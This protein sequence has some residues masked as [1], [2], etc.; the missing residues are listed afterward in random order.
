MRPNDVPVLQGN[1]ARA[2]AELGWTPHI[3]I[4]QTLRD[5]LEY[6]RGRVREE[7]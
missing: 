3:P 4:E 5:T 7:H 2:R 1:A 6:W